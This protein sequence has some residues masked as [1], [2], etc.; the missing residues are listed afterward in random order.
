MKKIQ[1][2]EKQHKKEANQIEAFECILSELDYE[3]QTL[4]KKIALLERKK[5]SQTTAA[6]SSSKS[7]SYGK[8]V[9]K[10]FIDLFIDFDIRSTH[11]SK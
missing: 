7:S 8:N 6:G 9:S 10:S 2:H 5:S 3:T 1:A 11:Y 4:V